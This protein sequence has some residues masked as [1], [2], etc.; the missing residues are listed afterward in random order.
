MRNISCAYIYYVA[1]TIQLQ[2]NVKSIVHPGGRTRAMSGEEVAARAAGR[3]YAV[4]R[5]SEPI[6]TGALGPRR[7][8]VGRRPRAGPDDDHRFPALPLAEPGN[9]GED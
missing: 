7:P 5:A 9:D 2:D 4:Q 3:R 8:S 1:R 6:V